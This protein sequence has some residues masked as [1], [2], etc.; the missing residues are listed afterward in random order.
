MRLEKKLNK[1]IEE[2]MRD[3]INERIAEGIKDHNWRKN[4]TAKRPVIKHETKIKDHE[5]FNNNTDYETRW[6]IAID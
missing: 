1:H 3:R 5:K 4:M 6:D 2:L